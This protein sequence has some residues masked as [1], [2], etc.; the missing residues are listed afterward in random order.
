M[1]K[2][3]DPPSNRTPL[4]AAVGD[5]PLIMLGVQGPSLIRGKSPTA[6]WITDINL[7]DKDS[8]L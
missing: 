7:E 8:F 3:S 4:P 5:F 1:S 6:A 2:R